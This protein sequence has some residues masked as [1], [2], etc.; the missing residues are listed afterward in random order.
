MNSTELPVACSLTA[1]QL[2]ERRSTLIS[3][4]KAIVREQRELES[5]YA[6]RFPSDQ[7]LLGDLANFIT[8]ERRCCPFLQFALRA[9]PN[10]GPIWLELTGPA[11][12]K[13]F[14]NSLFG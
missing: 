7:D 5:G 10:F 14:L 13:E 2:Q 6:Y 12:T 3:K 8:L 4:F 1:S 9:E 11:G